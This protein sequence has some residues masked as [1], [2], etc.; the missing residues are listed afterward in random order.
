MLP[1]FPEVAGRVGAG[2][3]AR[4][5]A[6]TAALRMV[7]YRYGGGRCRDTVL[8]YLPRARA[9]LGSP[10]TDRVAALLA[11]AVADL[12]NL[13][14]WACFDTGLVPAARR[15]FRRAL[16]LAGD[17]RRDDLVANIHYRIGRV[18]L[19]HHLPGAAAT[20][21]HLG[22][23]AARASGSHHPIALLSANQ[24]WAQAKLGHADRAAALLGQAAEEFTAARP[25]QLGP[26]AVFFGET[27]LSA[28]TGSVYA[29][30]GQTVHP[31]HARTAIPAL[32][33]AVAG[34]RE[35]MTRSQAFTLTALATCHLLDGD[36]DEG[37]RI[38]H[39]A[40]M[41]CAGLESVRVTDRLQP[42]RQA[43]AA[44]RTHSGVSGLYQRFVAENRRPHDYAAAGRQSG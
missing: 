2:D 41:L 17:A 14:G 36:L 43:A 21:F 8:G 37:A 35:E 30:L 4:I 7:D 32:S 29:D 40:A 15:H 27:D 9:L 22:R 3:V 34:Y 44:H 23:V 1:A 42:L 33:A 38:G 6:V 10:V 26:W 13:A 31:R 25:E 39:R 19:H 24:A 16:S 5:E 12:H 20:S 11:T 28:M 18:H